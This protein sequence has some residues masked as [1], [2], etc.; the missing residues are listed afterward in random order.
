MSN[1]TLYPAEHDIITG[2]WG[3]AVIPSF[4][5]RCGACP[6]YFAVTR[7]VVETSGLW[8][9]TSVRDLTCPYCATTLP[10]VPDQT[11]I[12]ENTRY[13]GED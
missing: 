7:D 4:T 10:T 6:K 3:G 13:H 9:I 11:R 5:I 8:E 12:L 2:T 1:H